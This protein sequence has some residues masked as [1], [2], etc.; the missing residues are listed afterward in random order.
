MTSLVAFP[1]S[2]ATLLSSRAVSKL[3]SLQP[4][5][6]HK[7]VLFLLLLT[8]SAVPFVLL[9]TAR[10]RCPCATSKRLWKDFLNCFAISILQSTNQSSKKKKEALL[11]IYCVHKVEI[12]T[13]ILSYDLRNSK[14]KEN[15]QSVKVIR[16][17]FNSFSFLYSIVSLDFPSVLCNISLPR[18]VLFH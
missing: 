12:K 18:C 2:S 6:L 15:V 17:R 5:L 8:L 9:F 1:P 11:C 4:P 13:P 3:S 7:S 16:E 10:S 14:D